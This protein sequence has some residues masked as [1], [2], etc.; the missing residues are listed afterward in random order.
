MNAVRAEPWEQNQSYRKTAE[1]NDANASQIAIHKPSDKATTPINCAAGGSA[2]TCRWL[3]PLP[4]SANLLVRSRTS[5]GEYVTLTRGPVTHLVRVKKGSPTP[6]AFDAVQRLSGSE[7]LGE[8]Y[9][10]GGVRPS[11]PVHGS[12][13][14][15]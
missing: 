5:G 13:T 8:I 6:A 14:R 10:G 9:G 2:K 3:L 12:M 11:R 7:G 4:P 15:F 1:N